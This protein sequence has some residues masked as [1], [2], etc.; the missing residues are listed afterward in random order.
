[1]GVIAVAIALLFSAFIFLPRF[2]A[3]PTT[4]APKPTQPPATSTQLPATSTQLPPTPTPAPTLGIGSTRASEK[5]GMVQ[6][7]VPAGA[8]SMGSDTGG[9]DE[10]PVHTVTLNAY[11][12]D[13]TE[14]T[15]AMFTKFVQATGYKTDA[16]KAGKAYVYTG[17]G[18]WQEVNGAQW[19]NPHGPSS[20]I[21]GLDLHPVAQMSWNDAQAYCSW[22]G[23]R[24]PTEA[25]WEKAA[26]G[27]KD[28]RLYPW[29][30]DKPN[31][32]LLNFAD[33][34]LDAS[35]A[36]KTTD[37]GYKFTAPV[38]SYPKGAS[39][40]GVFDM[41][42]NVW[43]WVNDWYDE[44]YYRNSPS[45]NPTGPTSGQYRALRGGSWGV[46]DYVVR[47]SDRYWIDLNVGFRCASSP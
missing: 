11:W 35:W 15:N 36:D 20:N 38:G 4:E 9:G 8:F 41:A 25:E 30:D 5:D 22:A 18:N 1:V 44:N 37:D 3:T 26:R 29:G 14:V 6:V 2:F 17:N 24:L 43:E 7:Y 47:V 21:T 39:P 19:R 33:K 28:K 40:Y 31:G 32:S 23:R 16:E 45:Q 42:G 13:K 34:N 12:I 46:S 27:D 10:K